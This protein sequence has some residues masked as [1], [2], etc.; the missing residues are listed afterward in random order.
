MDSYKR[1]GGWGIYIGIIACENGGR[2]RGSADAVE[3]TINVSSFSVI[4][5]TNGQPF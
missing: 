2:K 3:N 5:R 4:V 1:E